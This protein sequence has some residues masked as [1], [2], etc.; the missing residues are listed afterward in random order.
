MSSASQKEPRGHRALG[1][2][3]SLSG[4]AALSV[5][6]II[7]SLVY[8]GTYRSMVQIWL[9][10][11]TYL[12]GFIILPVSIYLVYRKWP[13]IK[14]I[15]RNQYF[16]GVIWL[17]AA[18]ITWFAADVFGIQSGKHFAAVAIIPAA[19]TTIMGV[20]FAMAIAFP[21]AFLFFSVPFGEFLVP[22]LQDV[23]AT[24]G[25]GLLRLTGIPA[26][27]D[28][29]FISIPAGDFVVAEACSGIRYLLATIALGTLYAYL[30]YRKT[31]K[32]L[33]FIGFSF[34]LPIF[35]NGIRAYLII[36]IAHYSDMKYAVGVDHLIYGW[37]FF[38]VVIGLMFFIGN[39]YRDDDPSGKQTISDDSRI[40]GSVARKGRS[41][42]IVFAAAAIVIGPLA[43][44]S[45]AD[46]F[47]QEIELSN[48]LP[49][50]VADWQ[51]TVLRDS[52]WSPSFVGAS[53]EVLARYSRS[54]KEIDAALI[55]YAR[56]QQGM[57]LAN[58]LNSVIG[59]NGWKPRNTR[60]RVVTLDGGD[61]I[62]LLET[63]AIKS[64]V[65]RRFWYWYVVD[66]KAV[67]SRAKIKLLEAY[68]VLAARPAM[69]SAIIVSVVDYDDSQEVLQSFLR[70]SYHSISDCLAAIALQP[71][72]GLGMSIG[73]SD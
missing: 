9:V 47:A 31:Y 29:L 55:R 40:E 43:S 32:R 2:M 62:E 61:T 23:T 57:E 19:V 16:W 63:L 66:N 6:L 49:N 72:C 44:V 3:P 24:F 65:M 26:Y 15:P 34:V 36:A 13:Q 71:N 68:S 1:S 42:L 39:R 30:N 18:S 8:F 10:S 12:H 28:G 60:V 21:L 20:P 22:G 67:V 56:R 17:L 59:S 7:A 50:A 48:G 38:G 54:G 58:N 70:D 5:L 11:D 52:D 14:S 73:E 27:I 33:I 45:L 4:P 53:Q 69:S 35:A 37:I 41:T 51:G 64:G 46:R 25:I